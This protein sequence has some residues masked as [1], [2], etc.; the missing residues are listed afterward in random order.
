M[1]QPDIPEQSIIPFLIQDQ[2]S[3]PPHSRIDLS[4]LVEVRGIGPGAVAG[5]QI[6]NGALAD[7][8]EEADVLVA[9]KMEKSSVCNQ[10]Q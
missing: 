10:S 7:I 8:D 1:L 3:I 6:E 2:L 4:V 5:M 9:S